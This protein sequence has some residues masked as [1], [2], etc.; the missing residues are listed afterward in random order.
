VLRRIFGLKRE[1]VAGGWRRLHNEELHNLYFLPNKI[2][3][4][5]SRKLRWAGR[6]AA[7]GRMRNVYKILV[8]KQEGKR[9]LG[10]PRCRWEDN[11]RMDLREVLWE[12]VDWVHLTQDMDHW[13]AVVNTVMNLRVP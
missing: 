12:G 8:W 9:P 4:I 5:K 10:R 3:V 6:E 1:E 2:R 11:I 13:G 7:V